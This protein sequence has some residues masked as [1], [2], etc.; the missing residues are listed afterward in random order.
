MLLHQNMIHTQYPMNKMPMRRKHG[1]SLFRR[2]NNHVAF[3]DIPINL[4]FITKLHS[5]VIE[6]F[7]S[8]QNHST[9]IS[10]MLVTKCVHMKCVIIEKL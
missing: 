10:M 8:L 9:A 7:L 2:P 4:Q 6:Y 5:E 3:R 1:S